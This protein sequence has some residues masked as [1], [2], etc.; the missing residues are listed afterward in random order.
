[1][2]ALQ[3]PMGTYGARA[4]QLAAQTTAGQGMLPPAAQQVAQAA[5]LARLAQVEKQ[6]KPARALTVA[7]P[8]W[9][10]RSAI[11][12]GAV[13]MRVK[14]EIRGA[15]MPHRCSVGAD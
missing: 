5:A 6:N 10:Q 11:G 14:S 12:A 15:G 1:M 9:A 4:A 2:L 7:V 3:Q 8:L 13:I